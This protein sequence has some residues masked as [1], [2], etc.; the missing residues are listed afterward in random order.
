MS[1]I[2]HSIRFVSFH[3]LPLQLHLEYVISI[4]CLTNIFA[5]AWPSCRHQLGNWRERKKEVHCVE[6]WEWAQLSCQL[7]RKNGN[8][9]GCEQHRIISQF[10]QTTE[11]WVSYV[12][13][14]VFFFCRSRGIQILC[15]GIPQN[16][17]K[18]QFVT[19][20]AQTQMHS[21]WII[22]A[23][24]LIKNSV[25]LLFSLQVLSKNQVSR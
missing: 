2:T 14:A 24:Y 15:W 4:S 12:E 11:N 13:N 25:F 7:S 20:E 17:R 8:A 18:S 5:Y 19:Y 22:L 3:S 16:I 6:A 23:N 1:R 10:S 21:N 9:D